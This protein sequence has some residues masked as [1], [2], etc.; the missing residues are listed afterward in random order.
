VELLLEQGVLLDEKVDRPDQAVEVLEAALAFQPANVAAQEAMFRAALRAGAWEKSA[1]ALEA[2]LVAGNPMDD[3]AERYHRL[4]RAAEAGGKVDRA[5]GFYSRSYAR[6]STYRPTLERLSEI[7]FDR[8]QWDNAWKATEHLIARHGADFPPPERA[9]LS[10]RSALADLHVAQRNAAAIRLASLLPGA[11]EN[12]GAAG[13]RDVAESWASMRFEPRLLGG[14]DN[15]R[16]ARAL[17]RL[18]EVLSLT[19]AIPEDASRAGARETLAAL[20]LCDRRWADAVSLLDGLG[21]EPSLDARRRCLF[22]CAAGDVVLFHQRDAAGAAARYRRARALN[23]H[24]PRLG[25]P[26]VTQLTTDPTGSIEL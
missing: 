15:E 5:L 1:Q 9:A 23:P 18:A 13:A 6:N 26:S 21:S 11:R 4:G 20:A 10:L 25:R 7:C 3:L 17:G 24:E 19:E 2:L 12:E 22:L 8:Q 14:V 16:R